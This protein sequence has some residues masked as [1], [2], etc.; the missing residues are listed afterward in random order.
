MIMLSD[1]LRIASLSSTSWVQDLVVVVLFVLQC[2]VSEEIR[3]RRGTEGPL[4]GRDAHRKIED[5]FFVAAYC[6]R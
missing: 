2:A 5:V 3:L 4:P 6:T 1:S